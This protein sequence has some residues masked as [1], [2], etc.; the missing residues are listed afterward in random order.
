[1]GSA[2]IQ[3]FLHLGVICRF[4]RHIHHGNANR[5]AQK[6]RCLSGH[7]FQNVRLVHRISHKGI[8]AAHFQNVAL[9][10]APQWRILGCHKE[11]GSRRLQFFPG[12][13]HQICPETGRCLCIG[14]RLRCRY[15]FILRWG[16]ILI[17]GKRRTFIVQI[18]RNSFLF[19][20]NR[21]RSYKLAGFN[22]VFQTGQPGIQT[23]RIQR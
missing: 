14:S 17:T 18:L 9:Q 6:C 10:G 8:Q 23:F 2:E 16:H 19:L 20:F 4:G 5:A 7:H 12:C 21:S 13:G 15:R 1:M 3:Q 11:T 22:L